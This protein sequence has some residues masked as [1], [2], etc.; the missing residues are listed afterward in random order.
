MNAT[1]FSEIQRL[2]ERTYA[3]VG[4]NLEDCLIDRQRCGQLSRAGRRL[5]AGTER[6]RAHLSARSGRPALRRH[7]LLALAH[8]AAR[9]ARSAARAER[10]K[11]PLPH[12]LR[13]GDQSRAARG[14]AVPA[15]RARD[16][17]AKISRAI[18]S[19]RRRSIPI[20]CC[21]SSSAF[22]RKT[23]KVSRTD[24]RWL[25]FHLFSRQTPHA[26]ADPNLRGRYL[27]TTRT[28]R[29]ATRSTSTRSTARAASMKSASSTRSITRRRSSASSR[30]PGRRRSSA[31]EERR[32]L[33][34]IGAGETNSLP[35]RAWRRR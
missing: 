25:R 23:Q 34:K 21:C 33:F 4:I 26:Y 8:R 35:L 2:F 20:S 22:F 18:S 13:G 9:A 32:R 12:R 1:L 10:R 5:G 7:L 19:C 16:R 28:G 3:Q 14:A 11:H 24:R 27:E 17:A 6:A 29:A 30:C 31:F 15:R